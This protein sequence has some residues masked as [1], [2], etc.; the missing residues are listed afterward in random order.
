MRSLHR[1]TSKLLLQ[2]AVT[3]GCLVP[4]LAGGA[5]LVLGPELVAA[6]LVGG[7]DLDS[8]FRYLSGL[9]LGI[10]I[11]YAASIPGIERHRGRFLM[12]GAIVVL[13]GLARLLSVLLAGP[14][15]PVMLGA[16]AIELV[17]TPALTVWQG[18]VAHRMSGRF[19]GR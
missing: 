10:G 1:Q 3:I 17:V 18:R 11:A 16:L 9:L 19:L 5:G 15:S 2:V 8:H 6:G 7:A 4:I 12:L 13:G 14:P